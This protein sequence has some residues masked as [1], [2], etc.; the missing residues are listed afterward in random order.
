MDT[1]HTHDPLNWEALMQGEY[2]ELSAM[3]AAKERRV[4]LQQ[5][6]LRKHPCSMLSFSMNIAG[7]VKNNPLILRAFTYGLEA[8][9]AQLYRIRAAI[10]EEHILR[11]ITGNEA[12][13]AIKLDPFVLKKLVSEIE[14]QESAGRLF[15]MDVLYLDHDEV[16]K[17]DR[18]EIGLAERS[19]LICGAPGRNCA[20]RRV[21]S[22]AELQ[23]KTAE[24]LDAYVRAE[25]ARKIAEYAVQAMLYEVSN[26]PKPGLVDRVNNGSHDDMDF[27]TFLNSSASLYPYFLKCTETGQNTAFADAP[28]T[29]DLLRDPGKQAERHMFSATRGVNTHKGAIF[30]LGILTAAAGR[31]S[32]RSLYSVEQTDH[33]DISAVLSECRAMTRDLISRDFAGI[34]RENAVTAGQRLYAEYGITGVRG[35]MADGLPAVA[36]YGLPVLRKMLSYGKT[37]D[38]AGASALLSILAH[39]TDTNMIHRSSLETQKEEN[40]KLL[41]ILQEDPCPDRNTLEE[42]DEHYIENHLSPGGSADL[43]AASWFLYFLENV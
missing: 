33:H 20:S 16:V 6:L 28:D 7:P 42:L 11:E 30:T 17:V 10:P 38:A 36:E 18:S 26:T 24:I 15:D 12:F 19:C 22:V 37:T 29:F 13:L 40:E 5:E 35:Q 34:T 4:Y 2:V 25:D 23:K 3:L 31:L 27:Y 1:V 9:H 43:L 14:E 41:H 8:V 32:V 21:H 39:T